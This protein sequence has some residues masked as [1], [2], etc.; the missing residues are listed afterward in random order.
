ME[1]NFNP[2]YNHLLNHHFIII[3]TILQMETLI[4]QVNPMQLH[5]LISIN[6]FVE[7]L[8]INL[9]IIVII[10][11]II[12]VNQIILLVRVNYPLTL[13]KQVIK[14]NRM[15]LMVII[16]IQ[17]YLLSIELIIKAIQ[18]NYHPL[19]IIIII[20]VRFNQINHLIMVTKVIQ[21]TLLLVTIIIIKV[22]QI[23]YH[24]LLVWVIN[25][26]PLLKEVVIKVITILTHRI[27]LNLHLLKVIQINHLTT[28]AIEVILLYYIILYYTHH[29][30]HTSHCDRWGCTKHSALSRGWILGL[31]K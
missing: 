6:Q 3:L 27:D 20:R 7:E 28:M 18:I 5:Y 8:Q 4:N 14:V 15:Y 1:Y 24:L 9:L 19:V 25:R 13:Q 31:A 17:I 26:T 23:N 21:R 10:M 30:T 22:I 11:V 2:Y 16:I 29:F 12:E